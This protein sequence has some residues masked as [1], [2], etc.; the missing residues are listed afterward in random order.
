MYLIALA[1]AIAISIAIAKISTNYR[2]LSN[3]VDVLESIISSRLSDIEIKIGMFTSFNESTDLSIDD[4]KSEQ[5]II[6][7]EMD[8]QKKIINSLMK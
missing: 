3:K 4:I 6:Y 1:F 7:S 8:R 2:K 5:K